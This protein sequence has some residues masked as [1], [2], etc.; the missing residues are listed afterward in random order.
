MLGSSPA[1]A[2]ATD[3][4][5]QFRLTSATTRLSH[6]MKIAWAGA[7]NGTQCAS[8]TISPSTDKF[9]GEGLASVKIPVAQLENLWL[10]AGDMAKADDPG[11]VL[12]VTGLY[13]DATFTRPAVP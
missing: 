7:V 12:I 10:K 6:D 5:V 1:S 11:C 4:V 13:T 8:V 2:A 3:S 9:P